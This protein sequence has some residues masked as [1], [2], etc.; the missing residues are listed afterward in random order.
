MYS[1]ICFYICECI[2][3]YDVR[4]IRYKHNRMLF[5]CKR[6]SLMFPD[7]RSI[8]FLGDLFRNRRHLS[9]K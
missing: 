8:S 6:D 4:V 9:H 1:I 7:V 3:T 5:S 2:C